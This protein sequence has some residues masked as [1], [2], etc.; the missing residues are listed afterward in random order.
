MLPLASTPTRAKSC[1]IIAALGD[2][3]GLRCEV[4]VGLNEIESMP[5]LEQMPE[6]HIYKA[7]GL[8]LLQS[9]HRFVKRLKR[10]HTPSLHGDRTWQSSF[11]LMD[12]LQHHP[13]QTRSR[14]MEVGCGWGAAGVYCAKTFGARVTSVD[15]DEHVFPYLKLLEV[16]NDVEV[17][18]LHKPF[19]KL[20][21]G[22]LAEEN[23]IVGAD[24]CFWDRMVKPMLNLVARAIRGGA[25]RV[26][27]ADP[28]RPPFYELVDCC[29]RRKGLRAEL[30]GW[31]AVEPE[32]S[33]GEV[34]EVRGPSTDVS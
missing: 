13:P 29:A 5:K 25:N 12:Y 14:V 15:A 31:Y 6:D 20:S 17:E 9:Q 7:Y 11:I 3:C 28:G 1:A 27:I 33:H 30:T 18:S 34:L 10:A 19:E 26:V 24:I 32:R 8:Y 16:L 2:I 22:R 21:T 4:K 23:L